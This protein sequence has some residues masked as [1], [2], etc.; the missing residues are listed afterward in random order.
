MPS[1]KNKESEN[2][3]VNRCVPIVM[4]EG[5]AKDSSQAVA[6]CHSMYQQW[7]KKRK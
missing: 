7:K 2:D 5:T 1:P 3:F 6:I 4:K